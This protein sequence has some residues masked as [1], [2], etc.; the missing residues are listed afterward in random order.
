MMVVLYEQEKAARE[1]KRKR[2]R[3]KNDLEELMKG[4]LKKLEGVIEWK[5]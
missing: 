5:M 4:G 1:A 3:M 2:K